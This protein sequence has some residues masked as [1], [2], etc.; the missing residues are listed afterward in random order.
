[1]PYGPRGEYITTQKIIRLRDF[2]DYADAYVT[3]PPYQRKRVWSRKKKQ[4]LLDS[5]LRRYYVPRLE[6]I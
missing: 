1:M 3:R 5:L 2:Y 4:A 6:R